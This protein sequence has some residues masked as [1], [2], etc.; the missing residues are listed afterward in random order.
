[1]EAFTRRA[2]AF[3][4]IQ[5]STSIC[6]TTTDITNC[7]EDEP[8]GFRNLTR[9]LNILQLELDI[10]SHFRDNARREGLALLSDKVQD[11]SAALKELQTLILEA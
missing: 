8:K 5:I 10:I 4:F 6:L 11:I 2:S 9:Q 1:M 7:F 3:V